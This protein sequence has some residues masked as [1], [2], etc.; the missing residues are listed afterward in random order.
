MRNPADGKVYPNLSGHLVR[1]QLMASNDEQ[2]KAIFNAGGH[3]CFTQPREY[4][5]IIAMLLNGGV[6]AK[7]G[8]R[9]LKAETVDKM[10]ENQIPEFPGFARQVRESSSLPGYAPSP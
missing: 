1:S 6:S 9:V 5:A 4:C 2:K 10:F 7:T 3:G 8:E